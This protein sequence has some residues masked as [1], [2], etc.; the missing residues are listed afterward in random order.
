MPVAVRTQCPVLTVNGVALSTMSAFGE[1]SRHR[2][3]GADVACRRVSKMAK[4]FCDSAQLAA[5]NLCYR[6]LT[7]MFLAPTR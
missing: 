1:Q 7:E 5:S 4:S 3:G 2:L 6:Y